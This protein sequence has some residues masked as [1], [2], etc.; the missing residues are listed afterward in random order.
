MKVELSYT[1]VHIEK[2]V[3][4]MQQLLQAKSA[5][6]GQQK[7]VSGGTG[8]GD[9]NDDSGGAGRAPREEGTTGAK[10]G[11][12]KVTTAGERVSNHSSRASDGSRPADDA[13]RRP[14]VPAGVLGPI[15]NMQRG[16]TIYSFF[17]GIST[18]DGDGILRSSFQRQPRVVPPVGKGEKRGFQKLKSEFLLKANML[19]ISG[20]FVGQGTRVISVGIPLKQKAVLL[21]EGFS[22]EEIRGAYRAWKFIHGALQSEVTCILPKQPFDHLEK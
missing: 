22:S 21:R 8:R 18:Q 17:V 20:H 4:M 10:V 6:G 15:I 3:G 1:R 16:E 5:D 2:M 11:V 13:G 7:E 12:T 19:D 14:D 9:A